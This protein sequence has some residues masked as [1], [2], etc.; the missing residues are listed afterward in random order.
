MEMKAALTVGAATAPTESS[1]D[2]LRYYL[3]CPLRKGRSRIAV[4][5]CHKQRCLWLT[6]E[7]GRTRCGYGD[8]NATIGN[9][10]KVNKI[11]RDGAI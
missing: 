1:S 8:P 9:R 7:D 2:D 11:Q 10:P 5:V 3:A 4:T 6:T